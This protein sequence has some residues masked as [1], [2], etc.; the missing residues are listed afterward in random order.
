MSTGER[1]GATTRRTEI[2]IPPQ[3]NKAGANTATTATVLK[4]GT[5]GEVQELRER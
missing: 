3:W 1:K 5:A 4:E 2:Q